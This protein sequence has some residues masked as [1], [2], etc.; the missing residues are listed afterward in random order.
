[1]TRGP[2]V[3]RSTLHPE[4]KEKDTRKRRQ[5][6]GWMKGRHIETGKGLGTSALMVEKSRVHG[7]G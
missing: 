5:D 4:K 6:T 1:M 7:E 2:D 3:P